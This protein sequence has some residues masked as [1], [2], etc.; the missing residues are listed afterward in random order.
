MIITSP[1]STK[2]LTPAQS[3]PARTWR[4]RL[5][6]RRMQKNIAFNL[7]IAPWLLGFIFLVLIP[8]LGGV[9]ISFTNYDGLNVGNL[10]FLGFRN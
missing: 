6:S 10:K 8:V 7:F 2:A 9:A 3:R 5:A 1:D 4:R